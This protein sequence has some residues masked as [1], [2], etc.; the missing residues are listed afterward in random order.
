MIKSTLMMIMAIAVFMYFPV[1]SQAENKS[2]EGIVTAIATDSVRV[3]DQDLG[4]EIKVE[5]NPDTKYQGL[6]ALT[7]LNGGDNVKIQYHEDGSKKTASM[8]SRKS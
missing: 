4:R 6:N 5:V 7:E 1:Y 8:I 3:L 2:M